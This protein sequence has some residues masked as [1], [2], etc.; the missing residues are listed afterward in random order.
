MRC[1][2]S[3]SSARCGARRETEE[4]PQQGDGH[5]HNGSDDEDV[6]A[7]AAE[8]IHRSDTSELTVRLS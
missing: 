4:E 6:N 5:Q 8:L 3:S 2:R 1:A 7:L